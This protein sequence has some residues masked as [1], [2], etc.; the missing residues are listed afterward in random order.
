VSWEDAQAFLRKLNERVPGGGFR[1]PTEAEWEFAA[2]AG[3]EA[4][5]SLEAVAWHGDA[6]RDA[7]PRSAGSKKPNRFG[8]HDMQGNV[9]EW[10]SSVMQPY[11]YDAG[12]GREAPTANR[13]RVLRGGGFSDTPDLLDPALRHSERPGRR[14]RMNGFRLA[15]SVPER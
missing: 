11:P 4:D 9:W 6:R 3:L 8:L 14:L 1:L 13:L 5:A 2:R 7:A 15:R 12:D 10:C